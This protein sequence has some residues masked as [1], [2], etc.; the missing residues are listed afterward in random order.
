MVCPQLEPVPAGWDLRASACAKVL[1]ADGADYWSFGPTDFD[2]RAEEMGSV[3]YSE[4]LYRGLSVLALRLA[5]YALRRPVKAVCVDCDH[6]L[7]NG[8]VGEDGPDHL[9]P[10]LPLQRAL[11]ACRERGLMLVMCSKNAEADVA[12][13]FRAHPEWPLAYSDFLLH[14]IN[15]RRAAQLRALACGGRR[16]RSPCSLR[17]T[18]LTPSP[19][20]ALCSRAGPRAPTCARRRRSSASPSGAPLCSSTTA[21]WRWPRC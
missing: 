1:C 16:R 2:A 8:V 13:A 6:T 20:R 15:W 14:Y 5:S 9:L 21:R 19:R 3:P 4:S 10:N 17:R 7:W 11:K 18:I 12:A